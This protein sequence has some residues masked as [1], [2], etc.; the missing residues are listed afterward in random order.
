[1]DKYKS[2]LWWT[3]R[4][5]PKARPPPAREAPSR[6]RKRGLHS[7]PATCCPWGVRGTSQPPAPS[8]WP[9]APRSQMEAAQEPRAGGRRSNSWG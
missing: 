6:V 8:L 7:L 5:Q 1:M 2:R 9:R 3:A 4:H